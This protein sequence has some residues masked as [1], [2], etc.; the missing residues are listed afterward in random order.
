[1][2]S[3]SPPSPS[4]TRLPS[5]IALAYCSMLR[6]DES[7][8][9]FADHLS[10][11]SATCR[12]QPRPHIFHPK[13]FTS[14]S[15]LDLFRIACSTVQ[16]SSDYATRTKLENLHLY[17]AFMR[18]EASCMG[19]MQG[20]RKRAKVWKFSTGFLSSGQLFYGVR[21]EGA[22]QFGEGLDMEGER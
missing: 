22:M 1:M 18:G 4:S 6:A 20:E 3:A 13:N 12:L 11:S 2:I 14:V 8:L 19:D 9:Y 15:L 16:Y 21:R 7:V 10:S 5:A 17:A